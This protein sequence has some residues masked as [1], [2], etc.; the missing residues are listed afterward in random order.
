MSPKVFSLHSHHCG[1][2]ASKPHDPILNING[3]TN[4]SSSESNDDKIRM[5]IVIFIL[6]AL[7]NNIINGRSQW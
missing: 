6:L 7:V 4:Y 1:L 3:N 2:G 5:T